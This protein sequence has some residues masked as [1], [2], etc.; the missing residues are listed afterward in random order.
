MNGTS[1]PA[2]QLVTYEANDP[3]VVTY[4]AKP[5]GVYAQVM[6][7]LYG[8]NDATH[9]TLLGARHF[10]QPERHLILPLNRT[11]AFRYYSFTLIGNVPEGSSD[12]LSFDLT[13]STAFTNRLR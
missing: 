3:A 8:S 6:L 11:H 10:P 1:Y 13:Y 12:F 9:F 5:L 2:H 4:G 7:F